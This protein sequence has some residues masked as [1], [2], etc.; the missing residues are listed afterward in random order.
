MRPVQLWL[1][2][3]TDNLATAESQRDA[4]RAMKAWKGEHRVWLLPD[5]KEEIHWYEPTE[6]GKNHLSVLAIPAEHLDCLDVFHIGDDGQVWGL[7]SASRF[8]ASRIDSLLTAWLNLFSLEG[9]VTLACAPESIPLKIPKIQGKEI[10]YE[11]SR[12]QLLPGPTFPITEVDESSRSVR[13]RWPPAAGMPEPIS[14]DA[15]SAEY[16]GP[17]QRVDDKGLPIAMSRRKPHIR[18]LHTICRLPRPFEELVPCGVGMD[19]LYGSLQMTDIA[20]QGAR[21]PE[22]ALQKAKNAA[23]LYLS[24][25]QTTQE[26]AWSLPALAQEGKEVAFKHAWFRLNLPDAR[27]PEKAMQSSAWQQEM[28]KL[29]PVRRAWGL[30]G[31]LWVLLLDQLEDG[32]TF[33]ACERCRRIF[34]GKRGKRFCGPGDNRTCFQQRRA[35]DRRR[36]RAM[37]SRAGQD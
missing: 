25:G 22:G 34:G 36:E 24:E 11:D 17:M 14:P 31:L 13:L 26:L 16:Y 29:V 27:T 2:T 7:A 15:E 37:H 8:P 5:V 35:A 3:L 30:L 32:R 20:Q 9:N 18:S 1:P 10:M 12:V 28:R 6:D 21:D 4:Q 33:Q 23:A 19:T